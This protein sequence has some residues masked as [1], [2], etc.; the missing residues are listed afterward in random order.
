VAEYFQQ[1]PKTDVD[2]D[3][4]V[5]LGAAI[6]AASL[7]DQGGDAY[8]LDVTPLSLQVG[9]AGGLSEPVIER[10]TPVPI[11]QTR[12]FTTAR[13]DQESVTI[14]V[15]QGESREASENEL[16]GQFEFSGFQRARRGEVEIDVTFEI[17]TDGIV[18]VTASDK[19]TGRQ[20]STRIT[21][22]SGL[23]EGEIQDIIRRGVAKRVA[24]EPAPAAR[25]AS[26]AAPA[27]AAGPALEYDDDDTL[28]P[29]EV[30]EEPETL[31][32]AAGSV[33]AP[34]IGAAS[35]LGAPT[36]GDRLD[37]RPTDG[38]SPE[39]LSE[40][41][42]TQPDL[43]AQP[44]VAREAAQADDAVLS[45]AELAEIADLDPSDLDAVIDDAGDGDSLFDTSAN[46][47]AA[48]DPDDSAV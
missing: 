2:P 41:A 44:A 28:T 34:E 17:D 22:S 21:L 12:T 31:F 3:E 9:V 4:V 33:E 29:L 45:D 46:D 32:G 1:P 16:L 18:N 11:E 30:D 47:L 25:A 26:A 35:E 37:G 42:T 38:L 10:N 5:A 23:S 14:R 8:L 24:E 20:A 48:E 36:G 7:V 15:F 39:M 19:S 6:H 13:D 40:E 27:A 43:P